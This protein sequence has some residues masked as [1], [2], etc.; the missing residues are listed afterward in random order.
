MAVAAASAMAAENPVLVN[1]SG[2]AVTG[3]SVTGASETGTVPTLQTTVTGAAKIECTKGEKS[4][5]TVTTTTG[6]TGMTSGSGTVTFTG[7]KTAA[8]SCENTGAAGSKEITGT[9]SVLLVWVGKEANKTIGLLFSILPFN[10]STTGNNLLSFV[11][12]GELI[13]VQGSFIALTKTK[14]GESFTKGKVIAKA[15]NGVQED[16]TYTENGVTGTNTL[17]SNQN[18]GPFAKAGEEIETEET[19]S[20]IVKV[21]EN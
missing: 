4:S 11:C 10:G 16:S 18:H 7:C 8:G 5:A 3:L 13:D 14:I 12:S 15:V 21:I 2:G 19:Y 9:V 17:Y 1:A 20:T 6:G